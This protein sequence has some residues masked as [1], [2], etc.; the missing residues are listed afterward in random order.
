MLLKLF[1]FCLSNE[2]ELFP[3]NFSL[4]LLNDKFW[5]MLSVMFSAKI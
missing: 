2:F 3:K 1:L 4:V 5:L